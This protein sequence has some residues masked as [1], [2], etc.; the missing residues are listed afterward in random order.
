MI[1]RGYRASIYVVARLFHL[2]LPFIRQGLPWV[3]CSPQ[4]SIIIAPAKADLLTSHDPSG[5]TPA[6]PAFSWDHP[7]LPADP[8]PK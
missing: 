4:V 3:D 1:V 2:P 5:L 7:A 8:H 6:A